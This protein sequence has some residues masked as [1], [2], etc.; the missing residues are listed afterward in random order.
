MTELHGVYERV[1]GEKDAFLR[2]IIPVVLD[3]AKISS[4]T[5]R[6]PTP[7]TGTIP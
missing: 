7:S 2:R 5:D 1:R 3:D 4:P 6:S